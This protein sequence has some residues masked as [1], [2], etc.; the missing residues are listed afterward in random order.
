MGRCKE[1]N[2]RAQVTLPL[3]IRPEAEE[4][5]SESYRWYERQRPGLGDDFLLRVEAA[6]DSI[7]YDPE[8]FATIHKDVRRKLIRRFP[9]GIFYVIGQNKISVLAIV[10]TKRHPKHWKNRI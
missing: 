1:K 6:L 7:S 2:K 5:L 4:D 10:H 9:Y 3:I 8:I